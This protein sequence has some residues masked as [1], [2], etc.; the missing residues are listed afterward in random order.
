MMNKHLLY[1][2]SMLAALFCFTACD[3]TEEA[4]EYDNW[5]VRNQQYVDSIAALAKDGTDG[6]K[7]V[8]AYN[9]ND[10]IENLVQNSNHYVYMK[11]LESG[12]G[13]DSVH[14]NDSVRVHYLGRLIPTDNYPEGYVFDKSYAGRTL[15]EATDVPAIMM[16]RD[17]VVGFA[18]AT[19]EMVEGDRCKIVIP[20]Y[21]GYGTQKSA[22]SSIL[23]YSALIFDVKLARIYRYQSDANTT[24]H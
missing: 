12:A 8:V 14:F 16:V 20:Y 4:S 3:E 9:L 18:T 17:N 7:R 19:M 15:N 21:L 1:I 22:S 5:Q 23:P 2:L 11:K 6:W 24:W 10:S 13:T